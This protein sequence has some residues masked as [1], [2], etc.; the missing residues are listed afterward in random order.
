MRG[1]KILKNGRF[2]NPNRSKGGQ[3]STAYLS[4]IGLGFRVKN[5]EIKEGINPKIKR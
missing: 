1:L 5:R 3:T 4:D 2:Q